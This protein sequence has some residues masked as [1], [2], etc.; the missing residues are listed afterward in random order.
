MTLKNTLKM[1]APIGFWNGAPIGAKSAPFGAEALKGNGNGAK[2][3]HSPPPMARRSLATP[4][5]RGFRGLRF[6][7]VK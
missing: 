2:V 4:F 5:L 3:R 1:A 7:C 6:G